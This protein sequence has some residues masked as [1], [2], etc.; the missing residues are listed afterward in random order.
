[1]SYKPGDP[2]W[3][4]ERGRHPVQRPAVVISASLDGTY[5][6]K[7]ATIDKVHATE[8]QLEPRKAGDKW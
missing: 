3:H 8:K 2:V 7:V 4:V 1:M 6:V 5:E